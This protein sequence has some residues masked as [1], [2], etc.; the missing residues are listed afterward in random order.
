MQHQQ[1]PIAADQNICL[2]CERQCQKLL[3][4]G[5][6]AERSYL[7]RAGILHYKQVH[8]SVKI[9]DECPTL[10]YIEVTIKLATAEHYLNLSQRFSTSADIT[11]AKC[12]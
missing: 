9:G 8:T 7:R 11:E 4:P 10:L 5:I 12:C 3:V 1:V 6:A 2:D